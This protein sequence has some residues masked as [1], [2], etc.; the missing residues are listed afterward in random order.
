MK[1][2][3]ALLS[4]APGATQL[5]DMRRHCK[6]EMIQ[7][8]FLAAETGKASLFPTRKKHGSLS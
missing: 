3:Y 7:I 5:S 4:W 1:I 2:N 6:L 8:K